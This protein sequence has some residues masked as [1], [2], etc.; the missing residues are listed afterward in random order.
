[1]LLLLA[2]LCGCGGGGG[3]ADSAPA[4]AASTVADVPVPGYARFTYPVSGQLGVSAGQKFQWTSVDGAVSYQLQIGT[5]AG[6]SD[7]FD[8][9]IV[10]DNSVAVPALPP[11]TTLYARVRAIPS[12]WGTALSGN[13]PRGTY[14]NFRSDGSVLGATFVAPAAGASLEA[15]APITWQADPLAKSYRL[16]LGS[17]AGGADLHDSGAIASALRVVPGLPPGMTVYA[18]LTTVYANNVS[19]AQSLSFVV[20]NAASSNAG[21]LEVARTLTGQVRAMADPDNQPYDA[22]PLDAQTAAA[23]VAVADCALFSA[24]LLKELAD[25]NVQLQ[26]R[27]LAVCLNTNSYDCHAL[28]EVLDNDSAR[29]VTLDPTFGLYAVNSQGQAATAAEISAAARAEAFDQIGYTYL[30]AAQAAYAH[31]YYIDYPLLFL[32]V[33]LPSS[34]QLRQPPPSSLLPYFDLIGASVQGAGSDYYAIQCA[35]GATSAVGDWDGTTQTYPC[36][37][38][39][40]AIFWGINVATIPNQTSGVAVWRTHR[41]VF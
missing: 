22:T 32:N 7:V 25:A 17:V 33:Y 11:S 13:W 37:N 4:S 2:A 16:T 15:D 10:T 23:G 28:V 1:M 34:T 40:T 21:M 6:G 29:W 12:G 18:T 31:A 9:G 38:G 35:A 19:R 8:S 20:G 14:V 30:T 26:S 24:T 3:G 36:T 5:S 41:F 27:S 39:F